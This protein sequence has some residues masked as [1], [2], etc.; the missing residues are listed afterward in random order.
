MTAS[1]LDISR[2]TIVVG[3]NRDDDD[4]AGSGL[5][6]YVYRKLRR[7]TGR[8]VVGRPEIDGD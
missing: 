1:V 4:G 7:M 8:S 2:E 6:S 3:S 5:G